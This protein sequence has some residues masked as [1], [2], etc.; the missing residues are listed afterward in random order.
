[1][2]RGPGK[3]RR[4]FEW[5]NASERK[6]RRKGNGR[7]EPQK[8]KNRPLKISECSAP[9]SLF[10]LETSDLQGTMA[11]ERSS[12]DKSKLELSHGVRRL[13]ELIWRVLHVNLRCYTRSLCFGFIGRPALGPLSANANPIRLEPCSLL[14]YFA[15]GKWQKGKRFIQHAAGKDMYI[16]YN[17][18]TPPCLLVFGIGDMLLACIP[19]SINLTRKTS[20][21][22]WKYPPVDGTGMLASLFHL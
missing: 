10:F 15:K 20:A 12:S 5:L 21:Y 16:I 22:T 14:E 11:P 7:N 17:G 6:Q 18:M 3:Y 1:M 19:G 9:P 8:R 13:L 4:P 2:F